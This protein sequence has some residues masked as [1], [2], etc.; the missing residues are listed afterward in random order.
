[1]NVNEMVNNN[2][3][4]KKSLNGP[5]VCRSSTF[6]SQLNQSTS[7]NKCIADC[8]VNCVKLVQFYTVVHLYTPIN[9]WFVISV[10]TRICVITD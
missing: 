4:T 3:T 9:V 10:D 6:S 8:T 7:V 2:L 5:Y 1:M